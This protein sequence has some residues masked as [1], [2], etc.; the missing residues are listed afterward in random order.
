[1]A[2]ITPEFQDEVCEHA[3]VYRAN[4][5]THIISESHQ[6]QAAQTNGWKDIAVTL[7]GRITVEQEVIAMADRLIRFFCCDEDASPARQHQQHQWERW[8]ADRATE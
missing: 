4:A 3:R 5:I 1:M 7:V 2:R 6:L 8:N